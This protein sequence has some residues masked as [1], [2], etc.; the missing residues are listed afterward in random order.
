MP[1]GNIISKDLERSLY[2]FVYEIRR[3]WIKIDFSSI[4]D[5][6]LRIKID[7]HYLEVEFELFADA[8]QVYQ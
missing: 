1:H 6:Y 3:K 8:H 5:R 7:A 2:N 4:Y